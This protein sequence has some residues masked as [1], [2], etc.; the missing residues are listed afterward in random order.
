VD[1]EESIARCP[2]RASA[3]KVA[4]YLGASSLYYAR[5]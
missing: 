1:V 2:T 5:M 3:R 4:G